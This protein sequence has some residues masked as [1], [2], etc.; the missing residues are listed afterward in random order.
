MHCT[1]KISDDLVWIGASDR[2]LSLFEA[3]YP[4]PDGV[5]YNSYLLSDDKTVLFDTVDKAVSAQ[6]FENLAY[7]LGDRKLDYVIVQ[8]MEPDHSATLW[9][10]L[11]AYPDAKIVTSAKALAMISQF[12]SALPAERVIT[13][14]EGDTLETGR[15]SLSF[16][17]APMV[18]WPE[19]IM[20]YD[21]ADKV[22]FTADAFGTFGALDGA[23]FADE[24]DFGKDHLDEAR[25]Y[26]CNIV[27]KYG[28]QVQTVL[29]KAAGLDIKMLCPLHGFVWRRELDT[30]IGK[31]DHWSKYEP[32]EK[33][34]LIAYTSVYG[35]TQSAAELAAA[36]L[37]EKGITVKM[38]DASMTH[39]SYVVAEAFRFSHIIFATT[40]YNNGIFIKMEE[41]LHD[42]VAHNFC[43]KTVGIIE[44]GSWAP[45]AG[46]LIRAMLEPC[47]DIRILDE[48]VTLKSSMKPENEAVMDAM[49]GKIATDFVKAVPAQNDSAVD[50]K[51]LFKISY[52][53]YVLTANDDGKDNGCII[54]TAQLL[55]DEPRRI[56]VAVN[57]KN[58]THDMILKTGKFNISVL[59]DKAPFD[60]Y[61]EFGFVSGR[62]KDKFADTP[63]EFSRSENG[64]VYIASNVNAYISGKV[65]DS[66]DYGTH[67]L[68]TAEVTAARIIG[69]GDS[70]TYDAYQKHIKPKPAP[71]KKKGFICTVCGY[72]YEGETLPP[73]FECPLCGHGAADFEEMN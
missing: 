66:Q 9:E 18:H 31:Y 45:A 65:V 60:T 29:K 54:N 42:L 36:K 22:L 47:K 13:V 37:R 56:T 58:L 15:H 34:V 24:V 20:T 51:A 32:E 26:Y 16:V 52:G 59:T 7:E 40:T 12:F 43:N 57:K 6:F 38:Y 46:K 33:G 30:I 1:R 63:I 44:N 55:T 62:D 72:I 10:L 4:V 68:F 41:L 27:G 48:Q 14:K 25:R 49:I 73:D 71:T 23:I 11:I 2:K 53:L 3:V 35:N 67:T 21:A 64:I 5:S 50:Q 39:T 61:K 8:H 19:V 69:E 70:V 28:T 17:A